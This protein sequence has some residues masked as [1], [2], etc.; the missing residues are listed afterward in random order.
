MNVSGTAELIVPITV[1]NI[2]IVTGMVE[3]S[4]TIFGLDNEGAQ[5]LGLAAEELFNVLASAA[6]P[7]EKIRIVVR[8]GGYYVEAACYFPRHAIPITALNITKVLNPDDESDIENLGIILAARVVDRLQL[9]RN[10]QGEMA[11]RFTIE[12]QYPE[13]IIPSGTLPA[14]HYSVGEGEVADGTIIAVLRLVHG[15]RPPGNSRSRVFDRMLIR[16]T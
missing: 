13:Q 6:S 4:A 14:G 8:Q 15:D 2:P 7:D 16:K 1:R 9:V 3:Q 5:N 11:L 12:R 10:Q